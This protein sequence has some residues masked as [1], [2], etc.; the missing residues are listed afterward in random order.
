MP[1][2][3]ADRLGLS[4]SACL[5]AHVINLWKASKLS[6]LEKLYLAWHQKD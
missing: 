2:L 6:T 3:G 5:S 4:L 1:T